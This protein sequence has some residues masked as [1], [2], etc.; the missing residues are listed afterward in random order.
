MSVDPHWDSVEL[1]LPVEESTWLWDRSDRGRV[2]TRATSAFTRVAGKYGLAMGRDGSGTGS[3]GHI[4]HD[5]AFNFA[6]AF[7][8]EFWAKR[9]TTSSA[10]GLLSKWNGSTSQCGWLIRYASGNINAILSTDG[11]THDLTLNGGAL[12]A[13]VYHR[14]CLERNASGLVRLYVEG[15]VVASGTLATALHGSTY[16][17]EVCGYDGGNSQSGAAVDDVRI[18]AGVARYDGAYTPPS[19]HV[20]EGTYRYT[21]PGG[22]GDRTSSITVTAPD[23][24]VTT[25]AN[26][27]NGDRAAGTSVAGT[28][29]GRLVFDF[30]NAVTIR[31]TRFYK[32]TG[33]TGTWRVEGSADG[34]SWDI[35]SGAVAVDGG[36]V[37]IQF[38]S[39][40]TAYRYYALNRTATGSTINWYE[41]EFD[42]L[43]D[44]GP[45]PPDA[46]TV[47]VDEIE[48]TTAR[49]TWTYD[50]PDSEAHT[51]S[52]MRFRRTSDDEIVYTS[53]ELGAVLTYT[54]PGGT[55]VAETE[56][57]AEARVGTADA[58]SAWGVSEAFT[59]A[60]PEPPAWWSE[61]SPLWDDLRG[62]WNQMSDLPRLF[63]VAKPGILLTG[64]VHDPSLL[65][66]IATG[67][68]KEFRVRSSVLLGGRGRWVGSQYHLAQR[69]LTAGVAVSASGIGRS[70]TKQSLFQSSGWAP[71]GE[72]DWWGFY[73][74]VR[75]GGSIITTD[76]GTEALVRRGTTYDGTGGG[77]LLVGMI[78]Q[79]DIPSGTGVAGR[80][81]ASFALPP[82]VVYSFNTDLAGGEGLFVEQPVRIDFMVRQHAPDV[83]MLL[84]KVIET[85]NTPPPHLYDAATDEY[86]HIRQTH[87]SAL[88]PVNMQ[89]GWAGIWGRSTWDLLVFCKQWALFSDF[90]AEVLDAGECEGTLPPLVPPPPAPIPLEECFNDTL[91]GVESR[92]EGFNMGSDGVWEGPTVLSIAPGGL[93]IEQPEGDASYNLVSRDTFDFRT[94]PTVIHIESVPGPSAN[95][96]GFFIGGN[97]DEG[98]AYVYLYFADY[99]GNG[100]V[101][102]DPQPI[103]GY[104]ESQQLDYE[105][106]PPDGLDFSVEKYWRITITQEGEGEDASWSV[107]VESAAF[108]HGPW[109]ERF[110][111]PRE[112]ESLDGPFDPGRVTIVAR[113]DIDDREVPQSFLIGGINCP[114][115]TADEAL[116]KIT[117]TTVERPEKP[118]DWTGLRK[119]DVP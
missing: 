51:R 36:V 69:S 18:T 79:E 55:L 16:R 82:G 27:V 3:I 104:A 77:R 83:V 37:G 105:T 11:S 53:D 74:G 2:M 56:Y 90:E 14:V 45:T 8:I 20:P 73:A 107:L 89:C 7:T 81:L 76:G 35:L 88:N 114:C 91:E 117:A 109:I 98:G 93:L 110:T 12:T 5:A 63:P 108:C 68:G 94:E 64:L 41:F 97:G 40:T 96:L 19:D 65:A 15:E 95:L 6:G 85:P 101:T 17:V 10:Q 24:A 22:S 99:T 92:W 42:I 44:L 78:A 71:I 106:H 39:N 67:P 47:T 48:A 57:V 50:H 32:A 31:E 70:T 34:V 118:T 25:P 21:N 28:P 113:G 13:G 87:G 86:W 46:P 4:P 54:P 52:Q 62:R 49:V 58:W 43:E 9:G 66:H 103:D 33:G 111:A 26:L 61:W 116:T 23:F 100:S 29:T 119:L 102:F 115:C 84:A 80:T 112:G 60:P 30:G 75:G 38:R 59:T 72:W 1:L